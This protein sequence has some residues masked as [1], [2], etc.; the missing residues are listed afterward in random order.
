MKI[1]ITGSNGYIGNFLT[2]HF[3][4]K[5]IQVIGIDLE[6]HERQKDYTHFIFEK[7]DV[8]EKDTIESIFQKH[9]PNV[10]IHLAYLMK[11]Q[12]DKQV[13]TDVD[14]TGSKHVIS[15][16]KNVEH[17]INYSS[18]SIY[19]GHKSNPLF[20]TEEYPLQP[21]DWVYAQNKKAVE[22]MLSNSKI[23]HINIRSCTVVGPSYFNEGGVVSAIAKGK[24]GVKLNFRDSLV[25]FIHEDDVINMI[26][27]IIAKKT[28][29]TYNFAPES[30][31]GVSE[32]NP[33]KLY[34]PFPTFVFKGI[35]SLLWNAKA[36]N[37]SPTS[38]NL[39]AH[40]IVVS[41]KKLAFDLDYK[42]D[43]STK[44][45]YLDAKDRRGL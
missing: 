21:R 38:V 1:L 10:V 43:Y 5:G 15:A 37:V 11:P 30:Y 18:S 33:N 9:R 42:F 39:I 7:G 14:V 2:K 35:I 40:G 13:E 41:S 23:H 4:E 34:I 25:Q 28:Q 17:F 44:E 31:A 16:A 22:E 32:L 3:S 8:R 45:A 19:G 6:S 29:G 27:L 36:I 12:R 26:E 24:I 20:I